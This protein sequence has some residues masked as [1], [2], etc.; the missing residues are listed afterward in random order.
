MNGHSH[1]VV[2]NFSDTQ[3]QLYSYVDASPI[4]PLTPVLSYFGVLLPLRY[5]DDPSVL[6]LSFPAY[7]YQ[8]NRMQVMIYD[9]VTGNRIY[10]RDLSNDDHS[11]RMWS[12]PDCSNFLSWT[13]WPTTSSA[14]SLS[15]FDMVYNKCS[16]DQLSSVIDPYPSLLITIHLDRDKVAAVRFWPFGQPPDSTTISSSSSSSSSPLP[17]SSSFP[18][19][20]SSEWLPIAIPSVSQR[21]H[22]PDIIPLSNNRIAIWTHGND[23]A[24]H[25]QSWL[26]MDAIVAPHLLCPLP[27]SSPSSSRALDMTVPT[28]LNQLMTVAFR[29]SSIPYIAVA[30][31]RY[32]SAASSASTRTCEWI[33][34]GIEG[35]SLNLPTSPSLQLWSL[36]SLKSLSSSSR[37]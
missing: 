8:L 10:S 19:F 29:S 12:I 3:T 26:I 14:P 18:S 20:V 24:L 15:S 6:W 9:L 35:E 5:H 11:A 25:P 4:G 23:P 30:Q 16:N 7:E 33:L 27:L 17:L 34:C 32:T 2:I 21:D 13:P 22:R 28:P 37:P 31:N 1:G 36:A